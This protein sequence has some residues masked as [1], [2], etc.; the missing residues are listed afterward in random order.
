MP[1]KPVKCLSDG[2]VHQIKD[3]DGLSLGVHIRQVSLIVVIKRESNFLSMD[4][5]ETKS[6]V[7]VFI[8][9]GVYRKRF[10]F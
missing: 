4:S 5:K 7:S 8:T 1:L 2:D 9:G 10:G 3:R 6:L